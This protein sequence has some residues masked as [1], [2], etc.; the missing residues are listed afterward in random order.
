M[1]LNNQVAMDRMENIGRVSPRLAHDFGFVGITARASGIDYDC[2]KYWSYATFP[3]SEFSV[4]TGSTGD[5]FC[6]A[7]VRIDEIAT[8]LALSSEVLNKLEE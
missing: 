7:K 8:S 3:F 5:V 1:L 6:R 4:S 2:R